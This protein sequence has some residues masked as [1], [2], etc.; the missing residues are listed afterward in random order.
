MFLSNRQSV[1]W[2]KFRFKYRRRLFR[3]FSSAYAMS[4]LW[5]S[6]LWSMRGAVGILALG[7]SISLAQL[8]VSIYGKLV[9][10][11]FEVHSE[12]S[13]AG[14]FGAS[15]AG[16]L[17]ATLNEY[18][19]LYPSSESLLVEKSTQIRK[20]FD[21]VQVYISDLPFVNIPRSSPLNKGSIA[22][23]G[24][25]LGGITI[26]L[27]QILFEGLGFLHKDTLRGSLELWGND[28]TARIFVAP[29]QELV[30]SVDKAKGFRALLDRLAVEIIREKNWMSSVRMQPLALV[31]F[32]A[33]LKSYAAY[34]TSGDQ[35]RLQFARAKYKEA[36][37]LD[38]SADIARLHLATAEFD[39]WDKSELRSAI[40]NFD[41]IRGSHVLKRHAQIGYVASILRYV[42]RSGD[43]T[44]AIQF[45]DRAI[46]ETLRWPVAEESAY[47]ER[48]A[49]LVLNG[50]AF[51]T[52]GTF[53]LP[54][55]S[56]S[57]SLK[58]T[59]RGV[60]L[61]SVFSKAEERYNAALDTINE[62]TKDNL[63][64]AH[65][66]R[67]Q[68]Q[69]RLRYLLH[70]KSDWLMLSSVPGETS[71]PDV[72]PILNNAVVAG[73]SLMEAKLRLPE[74]QR[75][76]FA[77]YLS[78][79]L[80]ESYLR[81]AAASLPEKREDMIEQAVR[82]LRSAVTSERKASHWSMLR[83]ADIAYAR[84][85]PREAIDWINTYLNES[86][87]SKLP[88][89]LLVDQ[90]ARGFGVLAE[91]AETRCDLIGALAAA[92]K[93]DSS[94]LLGRLLFTDLL[95]RSGDLAG[96]KAALLEAEN[97]PKLITQWQGHSMQLKMALVREK[98]EVVSNPT[99]GSP[100]RIKRL[101]EVILNRYPTTSD[102]VTDLHE[103][104]VLLDD[105]DLLTNLKFATNN[106]GYSTEGWVPKMMLRSSHPCGKSL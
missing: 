78:G 29:E 83:L 7:S 42:Q 64:L 45:L 23:D 81:L 67:L 66:Y 70:D 27:K 57:E 16:A 79:S 74:Q 17:A 30:V 47:S 48:F 94:N 5:C 68:V 34:S 2:A 61:P 76:G 25:N 10:L 71:P 15:F 63:D 72:I 69:L 1:K 32:T 85:R 35:E 92:L 43:C 60:E 28:L 105:K 91:S 20:S 75:E 104:A 93:T 103:L 36:V 11:P 21:V 90:N 33:G 3:G 56:C 95:R 49:R 89:G 96:A 99:N 26:P 58:R 37:K 82:L 101:A 40:D 46:D 4:W 24:I 98:I 86:G 80:A 88:F 6:T 54:N 12:Q 50:S 100:D 31:S 18:R 22:F 53:L 13:V 55:S 77:P 44:A 84:D 102:L 8:Y 39:S 65:R 62:I 38:P 41:I 73:V 51:H 59:I 19:A 52:V 97:N 87:V 106:K 9:I 14:D